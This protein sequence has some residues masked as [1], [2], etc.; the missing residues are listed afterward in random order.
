MHMLSLY[1]SLT[2][3]VED[4]KPA[5]PLQV[6]MYSCG[7]TVYQFAHIGNMRAYNTSDLLVRTLR[8]NGYDVK[9]VMNITDVGH[10]TQD[11]L[12][13]GDTGE[14]KM[15]KT[16]RLEGKTVWEVAQFYTDV[17]RKDY[18]ALNFSKPSRLCKAT[19][20]IKEQ[21]D[22]IRLL[23][24]KGFTYTT[25][26]GVYFDTA[27]Y[28]EY[29]KLSSLDQIKEGARVE[30]NEERKN[31]RDFAL[32]KFSYKD[33]RAFNAALDDR[34]AKRQMEWKSPWGKGFPGWHIECSAMSMKYLGKSFDIHTGGVDNK[35]IH[36]PNEIAQ[37]EAVT[38]KP[39]A[40]YWIHTAFMMISGEKISK[41]LGNGYTLYDLEQQN[42]D[43]LA[44]RYLYLQ[45]H[46]RQEMNFTFVA[47]DAAQNAFKKLVL[48]ISRWE[49]AALDSG[50]VPADVVKDYEDRFLDAI[51]ED[52]NMSKALAV[53]W[54]LVKSDL[55]SGAK[56]RILFKMDRVL[57]LDLENLSAQIRNAQ[58]II[59]GNILHMVEERQHLRKEKH[60]NAADKIRAEV[61]KL[62][63]VIEDIKKGIKVR[64]K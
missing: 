27:K 61:E 56:S 41:S 34:E 43:V 62:G 23:E 37:S 51:N 52:L 6:G 49:E 3:K 32:W 38:R 44:L 22:L 46:Y 60:F 47:L 42:Y 45:T 20:H 14:D 19:D 36:H 26:D 12:G 33:G 16:A 63:Y 28:P 4:F 8:Y 48:E 39:L 50:P 55:P 15:E 5:H 25:S 1:N 9:F 21:V 57:G 10:M 58:Q 2:K 24:E 30:M 40:K 11:Q 18:D 13:G 64:K 7:P 53:M 54:E 59:P 35:E 31:P 17:F 29:G